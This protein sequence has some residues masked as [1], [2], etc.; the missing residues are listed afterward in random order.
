[1]ELPS[2]CVAQIRSNL[3]GLF[4]IHLGWNTVPGH[5]KAYQIGKSEQQFYLQSYVAFGVKDALL[6]CEFLCL[7]CSD[8]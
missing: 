7:V 6:A 5:H 1:M 3:R 4:T 2:V 8:D